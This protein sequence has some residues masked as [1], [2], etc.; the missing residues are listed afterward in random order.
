M[1]DWSPFDDHLQRQQE[2][3]VLDAVSCA[4]TT[5]VKELHE[6]LTMHLL[7]TAGE[8][9]EDEGL[10]SCP[11]LDAGLDLGVSDVRSQ[12]VGRSFNRTWSHVALAQGDS[13]DFVLR[14]NQLKKLQLLCR[15]RFYAGN[16]ASLRGA[17]YDDLKEM[18]ANLLHRRE[19]RVQK[20]AEAQLKV[21][22]LERNPRVKGAVDAAMGH[23]RAVWRLCGGDGAGHC[24]NCLLPCLQML[25][26]AGEH[27]CFGDHTCVAPR[28]P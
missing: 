27:D 17:H 6:L 22:G 16:N 25:G 24:S 4:V 26:H 5:G 20:W 23:L 28:A 10:E 13:V 7:D 11:L 2:Q 8:I 21:K 18:L 14:R 15:H 1:Q 12:R 19:H 3:S 9:I